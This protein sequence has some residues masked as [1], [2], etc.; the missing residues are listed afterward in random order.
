MVGEERAPCEI[1]VA[2]SLFLSAPGSPRLIPS[3]PG[4]SFE[5]RPILMVSSGE[6]VVAGEKGEEEEQRRL[7]SCPSLTWGFCCRPHTHHSPRYMR[8]FLRVIH[9]HEGERRARPGAKKFTSFCRGRSAPPALSSMASVSGGGTFVATG[10][11]RE[12]LGRIS[13]VK[14][15]RQPDLE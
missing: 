7:F 14:R 6:P 5:S 2:T 15:C 4:F 9:G 1:E 3:A 8:Q 12:R 10:G 13:R 11:Q